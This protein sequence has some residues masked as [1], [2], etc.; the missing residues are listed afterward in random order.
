M[1]RGGGA[2]PG[3]AFVLGGAETVWRDLAA[4]RALAPGPALIIACNHAARDFDGPLDHW[5]TMHPELLPRWIAER[6]AAGRPDAGHL[7]AAAHRPASIEVRRLRSPGGSSG[8][9]AVFV[10]LELGLERMILCGIP[11]AQKVPHFDDE[12][13]RPWREARQY[14]PAWERAKAQMGD[15]VRSMGGYT[16][17]WLGSPTREWLDG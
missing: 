13:R 9:F 14:W 6:R 1:A 17:S 4:A 5:A 7:W 15:R 16:A 8:L 11:M 12:R 10:G 2:M 3:L